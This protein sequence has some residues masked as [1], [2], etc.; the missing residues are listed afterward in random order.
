MEHIAAVAYSIQH[1]A[2]IISGCVGCVG[3][4]ERQERQESDIGI[5]G[6]EAVWNR[7]IWNMEHRE[8]Q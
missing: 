2:Y 7:S 3:V 4:Q 8:Q 1:T 5:G 6:S